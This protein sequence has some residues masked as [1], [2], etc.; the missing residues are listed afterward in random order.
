MAPHV[1]LDD[2]VFDPWLTPGWPQNATLWCSEVVITPNW[3]VYAPL[4]V[5]VSAF[6]ALFFFFMC[7]LNR[8]A[9]PS[10]WKAPWMIIFYGYVSMQ[11]AAILLWGFLAHYE[12]TS[13]STL[14]R[15][16]RLFTFVP[17][18]WGGYWLVGQ[19]LIV[20]PLVDLKC[21]KWEGVFKAINWTIS[22]L[23]MCLYMYLEVGYQDPTSNPEFTKLE[24]FSRLLVYI[25]NFF[26]LI[27]VLFKHWV[28]SY[29]GALIYLVSAINAFAL[30]ITFQFSKKHPS[31]P[32]VRYQCLYYV[33]EGAALIILWK[34]FTMT[35]PLLADEDDLDEYR[36]HKMSKSYSI[37]YAI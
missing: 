5:V 11:L 14:A 27:E 22:L 26:V 3:H 1:N 28:F 19:Y 30:F 33:L 25:G 29:Q 4:T 35:R 37:Q 34:F 17:L 21:F 2:L 12:M 9:G 20:S 6:V 8:N 23:A 16:M 32:F 18:S 10:I 24:D 31:E 13:T 36:F 7:Y 15:I